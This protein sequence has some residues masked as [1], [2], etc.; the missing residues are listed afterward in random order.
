MFDLLKFPDKIMTAK[1]GD[2]FLVG[3]TAFVFESTG[4]SCFLTTD[5]EVDDSAWE[6]WPAED[7]P[8]PWKHVRHL[9]TGSAVFSRKDLIETLNSG[10]YAIS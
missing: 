8:Y 1:T 3:E 9:E 7:A 6:D 4:K 10:N 2:K 5:K